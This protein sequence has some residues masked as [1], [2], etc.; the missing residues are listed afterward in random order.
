MDHVMLDSST[1]HGSLLA[2]QFNYIYYYAYVCAPFKYKT[3]QFGQ[4]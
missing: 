2:N 1:T 4:E 3:S